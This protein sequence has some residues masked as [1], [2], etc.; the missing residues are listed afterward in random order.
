MIEAEAKEFERIADLTAILASLGIGVAV[1]VLNLQELGKPIAEVFQT[2]MQRFQIDMLIR[3]PARVH[4]FIQNRL[5]VC[6]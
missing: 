4:P 6:T 2:A 5:F 1:L 3:K